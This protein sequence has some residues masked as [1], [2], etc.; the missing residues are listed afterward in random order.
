MLL[1]PMDWTQRQIS[2]L[3][4]HQ[5]DTPS[6]SSEYSPISLAGEEN[7]PV[8][9]SLSCLQLSGKASDRHII[10]SSSF[11]TR[12]EQLSEAILTQVC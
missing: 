10:C 4:L 6:S 7:Q 1:T 2:K 5:N 11:Q 8:K 9:R 12:H 3:A